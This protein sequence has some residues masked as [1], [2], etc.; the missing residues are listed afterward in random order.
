MK[1]QRDSCLFFPEAILK[2]LPS[3]MPVSSTEF[4][5][6]DSFKPLIALFSRRI[7]QWSLEAFSG[8]YFSKW[9]PSNSPVYEQSFEAKRVNK[10]VLA[11]FFRRISQFSLE[12][13]SGRTSLNLFS[14]HHTLAIL[15]RTIVTL[16]SPS[17]L[18]SHWEVWREVCCVKIVEILRNNTKSVVESSWHPPMRHNTEHCPTSANDRR[19][20]PDCS[21]HMMYQ[22]RPWPFCGHQNCVFEILGT[23]RVGLAKLRGHRRRRAGARRGRCLPWP[24]S[25]TYPSSVSFWTLTI[26]DQM[27]PCSW[28]NHVWTALVFACC[29]DPIKDG[30]SAGPPLF[31]LEL[32][33]FLPCG[34]DGIIPQMR[35]NLVYTWW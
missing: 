23:F 33:L 26:S 6:Q 11:I 1:G 24:L 31:C 5:G 14:H 27:P 12:D 2:W 35:Q 19:V 18:V 9:L 34:F 28:A 32:E 15:A 22:L 3:K 30:S 25:S 17:M 20:V 4:R 8:R 7:S 29:N 21:S 10:A 13:F 16:A